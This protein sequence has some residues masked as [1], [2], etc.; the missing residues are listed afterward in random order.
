MSIICSLKGLKLAACLNAD[1]PFIWIED[2]TKDEKRLTAVLPSLFNASTHVLPNTRF[3][4]IHK[5]E[6]DAC[7]GKQ[8]LI[9]TSGVL[10]IDICAI[11][12]G[13]KILKD[14][15]K[16][17]PEHCILNKTTNQM[18]LASSSS[19]SLPFAAP[20]WALIIPLQLQRLANCSGSFRTKSQWNAI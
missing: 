17:R 19:S 4:M 11:Y 13:L 10:L 3:W 8:D 6:E 2:Q 20:T 16:S 15:L 18:V 9:S 14:S 12:D 7:Y 5:M 1:K